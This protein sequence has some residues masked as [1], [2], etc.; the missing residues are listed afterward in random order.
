MLFIKGVYARFVEYATWKH[1]LPYNNLPV[2]VLTHDI[3][4]ETSMV[5]LNDYSTWER[6]NNIS[7]TYFINTKYNSDYQNPAFYDQ[8]IPQ[9]RILAKQ[10]FDVGSHSVG[11]L[12]DFQNLP[13]GH[14]GNTKQNYK[15]YD[16]VNVSTGGTVLGELEVSKNLLENDLNVTVRAFRP[17]FLWDPF[18]IGLALDTLGYTQSSIHSANDVMTNFPYHLAKKREVDTEISRVLEMPISFFTDPNVSEKTD[19]IINKLNLVMGQV[20]ANYAPFIVLLHSTD[21]YKLSV[22]KELISSL[23]PKTLFMNIN[24]LA[25]YWLSREAFDFT[26]VVK[27]D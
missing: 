2:F 24:Q 12:R 18:A 7:T 10:G 13:L 5:I 26:Q 19:S 15:P 27:N 20:S 1:T 21:L 23:P 25:T 16:G 14:L 8:Y 17:G 9:M 22:Q 4:L 11:H 6:C 3:D